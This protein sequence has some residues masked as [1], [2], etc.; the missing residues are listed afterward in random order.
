LIKVYFRR[1]ANVSIAL[2]PILLVLG[3]SPASVAAPAAGPFAGFEGSWSGEG[4]VTLESG[5]KERLRCRATY[6][7]RGVSAADLDLRLICAS[8]SYKF[9]FTGTARAGGNGAI[10]GQWTENSRNVG[11]SISGAARGDRIQVLIESQAF[12]ADL[13]IVTRGARQSVSMQSRAAGDRVA[14][15]ITLRR[16]SR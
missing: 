14:V 2:L 11:G 5:S 7:V 12:S 1:L 8:D 4:T 13:S 15:V 3:G 10:G 16:Q 6:R 9:D